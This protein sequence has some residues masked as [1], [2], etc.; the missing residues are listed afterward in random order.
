MTG[1]PMNPDCLNG[2]HRACN[3]DAWDFLRD[4]PAPCCCPCH[5]GM[6]AA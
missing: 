3:E 2:K 5:D 4:E 1:Q 6:L